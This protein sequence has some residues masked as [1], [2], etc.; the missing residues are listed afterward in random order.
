[1]VKNSCGLFLRSTQNAEWLV[2]ARKLVRCTVYS[3]ERVEIGFVG[4]VGNNSNTT[5]LSCHED[6]STC[7]SKRRKNTLGRLAQRPGTN[8]SQP[9]IVHRAESWQTIKPSS[10]RSHISLPWAGEKF[11]YIPI[12]FFPSD[13][14]QH[15]LHCQSLIYILRKQK[16]TKGSEQKKAALRSSGFKLATKLA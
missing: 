11:F 7:T 1:M 6:A 13:N 8:Y 10:A 3:W 14:V 2:S 4:W 12:Y 9:Q 5:Y 15:Q 16:K